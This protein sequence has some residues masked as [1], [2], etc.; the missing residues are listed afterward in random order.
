MRALF[1]ATLAIQV[2]LAVSLVASR[3][4]PDHRIWPPPS[5][6]SWQFWFTWVG[7]G[8]SVAGTFAIGLLGWG[9]LPLPEPVRFGAGPV[10]L[11]GGAALGVS[12]V[13]ALSTHASLG[14]GDCLVRG[15]PYHYSRNPQ[16][17]ADVAVFAGWALLSSSPA[18]VCTSVGACLWFLLAPAAEEPWL[19]DRFGPAYESY[20]REVPRFLGVR[21]SSHAPIA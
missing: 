11:L 10:L 3:Y 14:L 2:L 1:V 19:R 7:F 4:W 12:A 17:V 18:G 15:G 20:C 9:S 6:R 16:Y 8:L 13:R 21:E 5:A